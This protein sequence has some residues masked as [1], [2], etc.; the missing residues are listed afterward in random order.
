[1]NIK[2]K[3]LVTFL[4]LA[5]V[6]VISVA[7]MEFF[8]A[9]NT[10]LHI[11]AGQLETLTDIKA[12][13]IQT[14]FDALEDNISIAQDYYNIKTNLPIVNKFSEDRANPDYI[15]AKEMLD[16]QLRKW[17][18]VKEEVSDIMLLNP[19]GKIVYSA[20]EEHMKWNPGGRLFD[21]GG[22]AFVDG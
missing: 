8:S 15:K 11:F 19:E 5:A 4:S 12:N 10:L 16:G 17:L 1:M 18:E 14:F 2:N 3:I 6:S 21:P 13:T 7:V 9:R 22:V 20:N